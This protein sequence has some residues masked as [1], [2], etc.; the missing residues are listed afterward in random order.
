MYVVTRE[1]TSVAV[2]LLRKH[3]RICIF[4]HSLSSFCFALIFSLFQTF[5]Y[6]YVSRMVVARHY[7]Y[8]INKTRKILKW[9]SICAD[10]ELP[11]LKMDMIWK[12]NK[13]KYFIQLIFWLT[14]LICWPFN[15][16]SHSEQKK[17]TH[18]QSWTNMNSTNR[19]KNNV[20]IHHFWHDF[21]IQEQSFDAYFIFSQ[22]I[23]NKS[24]QHKITFNNQWIS[25][26][27]KDI[28]ENVVVTALF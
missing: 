6:V 8:R 14:T 16:S 21:R 2:S 1:W 18:E 12:I 9:I 15:L 11:N 3:I 22:S 19:T 10:Y 23:Y 27:L 7:Y 28:N 4:S 17:N 25:F 13:R 24:S 26:K 5:G 20:C